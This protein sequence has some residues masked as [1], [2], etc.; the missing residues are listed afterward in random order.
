MIPLQVSSMSKTHHVFSE[1]NVDEGC[2]ELVMDHHADGGT[3]HLKKAEDH[4]VHY[5]HSSCC[6]DNVLVKNQKQ[7]KELDFDS[8]VL[9]VF[10]SKSLVSKRLFFLNLERNL[11]PPLVAHKVLRV[12]RLLI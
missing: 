7:F 8:V 12:T 10:E 11:T 4:D 2:F 9:P 6:F 3:N 1:F 5:F